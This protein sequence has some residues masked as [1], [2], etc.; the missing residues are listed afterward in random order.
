[1]QNRVEELR[2]QH[3]WSAKELGIAMSAM[4]EGVPLNL[5]M[6]GK[7]NFVDSFNRFLSDTSPL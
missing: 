3:N 7:E 1:M 2:Q 5:H 6:V 4:D